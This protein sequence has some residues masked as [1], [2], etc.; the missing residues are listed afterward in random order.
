MFAVGVRLKAVKNRSALWDLRG[1]PLP[2][3]GS[4]GEPSLRGSRG[5]LLGNDG[6]GAALAFGFIDEGPTDT[7][8]ATT[9]SHGGNGNGRARFS[10]QYLGTCRRRTP[11]TRTDLEGA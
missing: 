9:E 2:M 6:D 8:L 1:V 7:W 3:P 10:F 5:S 11:R 4:V